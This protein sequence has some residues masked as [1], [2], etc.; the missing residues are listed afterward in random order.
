[1][2]ANVQSGTGTRAQLGFCPAAGKTGT[3]SSFTDAWFD[4]MTSNLNTA[5]W[6]G[7]PSATTS[8]TS[9]S[10]AGGGGEMFGGDAPAQ[11]WHDYMAGAVDRKTCH[12]WPQP[13]E[14]FVAQPF[15][16]KYATQGAPGGKSDNGLGT[17]TQTTQTTPNDKPANGKSNGGG[18]TNGTGGGTKYPPSQYESPPQTTPQV[19]VPPPDGTTS[20]PPAATGGDPGAG[21]APP[22]AG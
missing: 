9:V 6:V 15:F 22:G 14:P 21:G 12:D 18:T 10:W 11:I 3:T 2:K 4:G 16:G 17:G 8:M 13:K 20:P 7:Y 1:M 5:V 19:E